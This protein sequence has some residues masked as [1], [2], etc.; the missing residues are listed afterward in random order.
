MV[1]RIGEV[2]IVQQIKAYNA[3][4]VGMKADLGVLKAQT[5]L[6]KQDCEQYT[7]YA[8]DDD[9]RET[10]TAAKTGLEVLEKTASTAQIDGIGK[11]IKKLEMLAKEVS[12]AMNKGEII[13][14]GLKLIAKIEKRFSEAQSNLE[15]GWVVYSKRQSAF[16]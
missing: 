11:D 8:S 5:S 15:E 1:V 14:E 16:K 2:D 12:M 10:V 3:E 9:E 6:L 4:C 13:K 7:A